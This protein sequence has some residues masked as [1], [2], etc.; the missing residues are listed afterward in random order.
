MELLFAWEKEL[1]PLG[2]YLLSLPERVVRSATALSAGLVREIGNVTLPKAVRRTTLYQTMVESTLR[3][4]VEQVGEVDGVYP[5]EGML[6]EKFLWKRTLGDGIDLAGIVAFHA[7]PVWVFAALAD[8]SGAGRQLLDE[9]ALNLKNEGLLDRATSFE[10]LDQILDGLERT[11]G[12]LATSIRFPPLDV[13]GLRKEWSELKASAR[14][15][16][17]P[18]LPSPALVRQEWENLKEE[19]AGQGRTILELSSLLALSSVRAV[20][21][22]L[23]WLSRCARTATLRTGQFFA[24]GLLDHYR[25]TLGEIRRTGYVAYWTR[26]FRPYLRAAA[27]Q[28]APAHRSLTERL[29]LRRKPP[30][31]DLPKLQG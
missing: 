28:F 10:N 31:P 29:L 8:L 17:P 15:I 26:E 9:I 11:A 3:F 1:T 2:P 27:G 20:P 24:E 21:A 14:S 25:A 5:N 6:A 4:L 30:A 13:P 16:P 7:S 22:N 12:Q 18:S 23:L 19:A